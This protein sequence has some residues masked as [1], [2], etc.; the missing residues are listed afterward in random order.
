MNGSCGGEWA[1]CFAYCDVSSDICP[2]Q[3]F[4]ETL[5]VGVDLQHAPELSNPA[6]ENDAAPEQVGHGWKIFV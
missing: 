5:C 6:F 2:Q 3:R 1:V 4:H